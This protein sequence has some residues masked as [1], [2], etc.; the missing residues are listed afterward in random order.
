[1]PKEGNMCLLSWSDLLAL[2]S[3]V[4]SWAS[5]LPWSRPQT[6]LPALDLREYITKTQLITWRTDKVN[7]NYS[8]S[9]RERD[10]SGVHVIS[11]I[12]RGRILSTTTGG[13][14]AAQAASTGSHDVEQQRAG[15]IAKAKGYC[16]R[17]SF[18]HAGSL[19]PSFLSLM[20]TL[21]FF[22]YASLP[23]MWSFN[24]AL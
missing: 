8:E 10:Y 4:A 18:G 21:I 3:V 13:N 7:V 17:R 20:K 14:W 23:R 11:L 24:A 15:M 22:L 19:L 9:Q 12:S 5:S 16:R 1:M 6:H 2:R